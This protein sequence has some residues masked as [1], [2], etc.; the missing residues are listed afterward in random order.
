MPR[1]TLFL[2][3]TKHAPEF[4]RL[5]EELAHALSDDYEVFFDEAS[6]PVGNTYDDRI[7]R[8]IQKSDGMIFLASPAALEEGRYTL[9]ELKFAKQ[10]WRSGKGR[11]LPVIL[12]G[13]KIE[14]LDAYLSILN[15]LRPAGNARAEI[16]AETR[17]MWP[18]RT[19]SAFARGTT[20]ASVSLIFA[21]LFLLPTSWWTSFQKSGADFAK[22][23]TASSAD[24]KDTKPSRAGEADLTPAAPDDTGM[25]TPSGDIQ[26]DATTGPHAYVP[27][28]SPQL[29]LIFD[30][31]GWSEEELELVE[32]GSC[33]PVGGSSDAELL[34]AVWII[35]AATRAPGDR[36][37]KINRSEW[38]SLEPLLRQGCP[39]GL[40]N[41]SEV[42]MFHIISEDEGR[43]LV[44]ELKKAGYLSDVPPG[45]TLADSVVR[46]LCPAYAEN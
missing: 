1:K 31:A 46:R 5:A 22:W 7:W 20:L 45:A 11:V 34:D 30:G 21:V 39:T 6:L 44:E 37:G 2:S 3:H 15:V 41:F 28:P 10:K 43:A 25:Q 8:A 17:R 42:L 4:A 18:P 38:S 35:E 16:L 13:A 14:D 40:K 36:D 33:L 29:S 24:P 12:G 23:I 9:T 32:S 27:P 19:R 26:K